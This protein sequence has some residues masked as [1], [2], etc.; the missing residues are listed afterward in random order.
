MLSP[1]NSLFTSWS[2]QL[3]S[4][5]ILISLDNYWMTSC[6]GL[7][8]WTTDST[9]GHRV[10]FMKVD[11]S[12]FQHTRILLSHSLH[13]WSTAREC[14]FMMIRSA[15]QRAGPWKNKC[16]KGNTY[17]T[18]V[19]DRYHGTG[20]NSFQISSLTKL[21]IS[22]SVLWPL[23][24]RNTPSFTLET[25]QKWLTTVNHHLQLT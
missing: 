25:K 8:R 20:S 22:S 5:I 1:H 15:I 18:D 12:Y 6:H 21:T 7:R 3:I 4:I 9:I 13:R 17:C 11:H 19:G 2:S 14:V 23:Y 16:Q 10:T 24:W